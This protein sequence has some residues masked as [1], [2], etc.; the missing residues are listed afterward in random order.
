MKYLTTEYLFKK[1]INS[2]APKIPRKEGLGC[3]TKVQSEPGKLHRESG[4]R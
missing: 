2:A 3:W 4:K 1:E